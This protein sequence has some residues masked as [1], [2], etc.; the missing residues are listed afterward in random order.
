[1]TMAE[2][3]MLVVQI[4]LGRERES[5][6]KAMTWSSSPFLEKRVKPGSLACQNEKILTYGPRNQTIEHLGRPGM[7]RVRCV[8]EKGKKE[9]TPR[10]FADCDRGGESKSSTA[11]RR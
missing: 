10:T 8:R 4:T 3:V 7:H 11:T 2:A 6:A 9:T 1:M 5:N